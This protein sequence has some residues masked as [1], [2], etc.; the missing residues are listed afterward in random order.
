MKGRRYLD[1]HS[2]PL[3]QRLELLKQLDETIDFAKSV[4]QLGVVLVLHE[5][6]DG[7]SVDELCVKLGE[8]RKALLDALRKLEL[9]QIITKKDVENKQVIVLT[10]S[11]VSYVEKL[12]NILLPRTEVSGIQSLDTR[13]KRAMLLNNLVESHYIYT[14]IVAL[15]EKSDKTLSLEKLAEVMGLSPERAKSYLDVFCLPPN[16]IFR[17]IQRP[18][19]GTFYRLEEEGL[20]IYYRTPDFRRKKIRQKLM[21]R[22]EMRIVV[23]SSLLSSIIGYYLYDSLFIPLL[24][25][26]PTFLLLLFKEFSTKMK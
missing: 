12:L 3:A 13:S 15:G 24:I 18:G 14:A 6:K 22:G 21:D 7:L 9:K 23:L 17:R 20:K 26:S 10:E 19:K 2:N 8:R 5:H 25:F 16:R 1:L 4:I 11:G